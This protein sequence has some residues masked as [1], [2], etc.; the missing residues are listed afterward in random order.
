MHIAI[1]QNHRK[2]SELSKLIK[3]VLGMCE[4][5]G[6]VTQF[7]GEKLGWGYNEKEGKAACD[8]LKYVHKLSKRM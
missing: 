5:F 8:F 6:N 2:H 7:V 3:S 1:L 4:L